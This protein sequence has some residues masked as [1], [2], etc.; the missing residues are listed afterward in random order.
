[1]VPPGGQGHQDDP[2]R[3]PR[4]RQHLPGRPRG[5]PPWRP[6]PA[7]RRPVPGRGRQDHVD[8]PDAV[9]PLTGRRRAPTPD[10][11]LG[12]PRRPAP[13]HGAASGYRAGEPP[14]APLPASASGTG[15]LTGSPTPILLA[16]LIFGFAA[17]SASIV[18]P[19]FF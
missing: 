6:Q 4:P 2:G 13:I 12:A 14:C 8:Q 1:L 16:F 7:P 3:R 9:L 17:S 15:M 19:N 10:L 11:A 18:T 5:P